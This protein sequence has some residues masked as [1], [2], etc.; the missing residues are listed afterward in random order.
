MN[1]QITNLNNTY[2]LS[3]TLSKW[4]VNLF[5]KEFHN[6]FDKQ[7][8]LIIDMENLLSIDRYGVMAL[9]QLHNEALVK[10]KKISII[11]MGDS[12]FKSKDTA[13]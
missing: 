3:G 10:G 8:F 6:I 1:L 5:K 2:Q 13:A 11:G 7:G 4:N 12:D 9:A